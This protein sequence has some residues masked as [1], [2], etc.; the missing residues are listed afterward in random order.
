METFTF[1]IGPNDAVCLS[2]FFFH[3][4][5]ASQY[6]GST[7]SQILPLNRLMPT[8]DAAEANPRQRMLYN[9]LGCR[10]PRFRP[11]PAM[12]E[13][14]M[15]I[16]ARNLEGTMR[17]LSVCRRLKSVFAFE[18]GCAISSSTG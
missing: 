11:R 3:F 18:C 8:T 5:P 10:L 13:M 17:N 16:V 15:F 7:F 1:G 6:G 9:P 14:V 12:S 2:R 4:E